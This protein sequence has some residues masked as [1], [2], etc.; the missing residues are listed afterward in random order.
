[1]KRTLINFVPITLPLIIAMAICLY[2]YALSYGAEEI[3]TVDS[4]QAVPV[5]ADMESTNAY[6]DEAPEQVQT[7]EVEK[8]TQEYLLSGNISIDGYMF[9]VTSINS[10]DVVDDYRVRFTITGNIY[11]TINS[12]RFGCYSI[13]G[14]TDSYSGYAVWNTDGTLSEFS[15]R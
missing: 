1:M 8:L 15:I 2:P 5:S 9:D 4:A 11:E 13:F 7:I 3:V 10:I 6:S 12:S 14:D